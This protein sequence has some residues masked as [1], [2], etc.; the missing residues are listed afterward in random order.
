M[1]S[2]GINLRQGDQSVPETLTGVVIR[3]LILWVAPA[4]NPA[5]SALPGQQPGK[6]Y[7]PL[8]PSGG[9]CELCVPWTCVA[10]SPLDSPS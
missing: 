5:V 3:K 4:R 2:G 6:F 1:E 7:P 9:L 8:S 10:L